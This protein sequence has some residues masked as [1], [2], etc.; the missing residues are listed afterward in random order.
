[1]KILLTFILITSFLSNTRP[2]NLK[3]PTLVKIN[4]TLYAGIS[5]VTVYEWK[6]FLYESRHPGSFNKVGKKIFENDSLYWNLI[7]KQ[8]ENISSDYFL[9]AEYSMCPAIGISHKEALEFCKWV[10]E[11]VHSHFKD[12]NQYTYRLPSEA[13]WEYIA[14]YNSGLKN[15]R[16]GYKIIYNTSD[17]IIVKSDL[18]K[19]FSYRSYCYMD[20]IRLLSIDDSH[21]SN[22]GLVHV[23][24]NVSEMVQEEYVSKGG[25]FKEL[26][27]ECSFT[28]KQKYS[29]AEVWLGF[30][31]IV[32]KKQ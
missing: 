12:G 17:K 9:K 21:K 26:L 30:R 22:S 20:S 1:M 27:S 2:P 14:S 15:N 23:T 31:Y 5:E 29:K 11:I 19:L 6:K 7:S 4:D 25:N 16:K 8:F 13:E 28:N 18:S 24:G 32:V 10:T 3:D